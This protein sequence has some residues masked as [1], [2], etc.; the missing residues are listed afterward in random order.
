MALYVVSLST[1]PA[2]RGM[3]AGAAKLSAL[4]E[5]MARGVKYMLK[6]YELAKRSIC[7]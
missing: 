3:T 2:C 7:I 1:G 6:I 4:R 5:R